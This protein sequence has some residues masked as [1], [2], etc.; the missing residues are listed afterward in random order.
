[1]NKMITITKSLSRR[2]M[3]YYKELPEFVRDLD[4][5]MPISQSHEL[6]G[7]YLKLGLPTGLEVIHGAVHGVPEFYD[8]VR[9]PIVKEFLERHILV[10]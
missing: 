7:G 10:E 3:F 5:Q 1:M 8:E 4:P 2:E 9:F 6:H